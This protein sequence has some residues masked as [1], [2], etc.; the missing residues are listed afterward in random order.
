[1]NVSIVGANYS[2]LLTAALLNPE[3]NIRIH[4]FD[5]NKITLLR[6][7][8]LQI[9][10]P[11]LS[12]YLYR[13]D[14]AVEFEAIVDTDDSWIEQSDV[15]MLFLKP[16]E[17]EQIVAKINTVN[18]MAKVILSGIIPIQ[19]CDALI[20]QYSM[21]V[22]YISNNYTEGFAIKNAR[23]AKSMIIGRSSTIKQDDALELAKLLF[24]TRENQYTYYVVPNRVAIMAKLVHDTYLALHIGFANELNQLC[25][26]ADIDYNSMKDLLNTDYRIHPTYM[27]PG[28]GFGG[29]GLVEASKALSNQYSELVGKWMPRSSKPRGILA[30]LVDSNSSAHGC[31][32]TWITEILDKYKEA[33]VIGI[34]GLT[35]KQNGN[36]LTESRYYDIAKALESENLLSSDFSDIIVYDEAVDK[37][38]LMDHPI[39]SLETSLEQ[40]LQKADILIVNHEKYA[41]VLEDATAKVVIDFSGTVK[42]EQ[43]KELYSWI[44]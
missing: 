32:Y 2:G 36:D 16:T 22:L 34:L 4:D 41:K 25:H 1:M 30:A 8:Q 29:T 24:D 39:L 10:E 43:R 28:P 26:A 38:M 5:N 20:A 33:K 23:N 44:A 3:L 35:F 14:N 21:Q 7:K 13:R 42:P 18:P 40:V 19:A 9:K 31:A 11:E 17:I 12:D 15:F 27:V 6:D 37:S